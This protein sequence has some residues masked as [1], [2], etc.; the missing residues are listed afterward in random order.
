MKRTSTVRV[1]FDSDNYAEAVVTTFTKGG[2][3]RDEAQKTHDE[4][5]DNVV[6]AIRSLPFLGSAPL[7]NVKIR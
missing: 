6:G 7:R 2:L 3:T 4:A 1:K 5:T